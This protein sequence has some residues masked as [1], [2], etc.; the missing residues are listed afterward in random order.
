MQLRT[1]S[2][3]EQLAIISSYILLLHENRSLSIS[4]IGEKPELVFQF[5]GIPCE[6]SKIISLGYSFLI[7]DGRKRQLLQIDTR[8][9]LNV[10]VV[11][12]FVFAINVKW[13]CT[14]SETGRLF[15]L[16]AGQ[17]S[18]AIWVTHRDSI[19]YQSMTLDSN[20]RINTTVALSRGLISHDDDSRV[21]LHSNQQD[22]KS[23]LLGQ[24]DILASRGNHLA[25]VERTNQKLIVYDLRT[26]LCGSI[27]LKTPLD[28]LCFTSDEKY[29]LGVSR[30]ESLLLMFAVDTE[31]DRETLSR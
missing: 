2:S 23:V 10:K 12:Q 1:A 7:I 26:N 14:S 21:Y 15:I 22:T 8:C 25:L 16:S 4:L 28:V 13:I 5:N 11:A 29:L 18:L 3:V 9:P 27:R 20:T 17:S 30:Q 24:A 19:T 31:T 6:S